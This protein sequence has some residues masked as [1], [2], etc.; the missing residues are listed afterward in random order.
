MN[1]TI[2]GKPEFYLDLDV[3]TVDQLMWLSERHYDFTCRKASEGGGLLFGWR[4][5]II[6]NNQRLEEERLEG[7][8]PVDVFYCHPHGSFR[9]LDLTMKICEGRGQIKDEKKRALVDAYAI[10]VITALRDSKRVAS[11]MSEK[12]AG[13]WRID[14]VD[15]VMAAED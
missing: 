5:T 1:L 14:M 11:Y 13:E 8:T 9:D 3:Q 4:N 7:R 10:K 6:S 2:I 15:E 12:Q